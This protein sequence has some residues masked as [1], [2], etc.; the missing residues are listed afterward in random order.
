MKERSTMSGLA[1]NLTKHAVLEATKQMP[2]GGDFVWDGQ[3]EDERP[4][5]KEEMKT[6]IKRG[7]PKAEVTKK[8][9]TIRLSNDTV[10]YLRST[11]KG[12][13]TRLDNKLH[14]LIRN[15]EI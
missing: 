11:G 6:A 15:D 10:T 14:E 8:S 7:R 13:Q 2:D 9:I 4:L 5:S 1:M 3:N 12:W